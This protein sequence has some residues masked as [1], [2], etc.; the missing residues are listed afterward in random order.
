MARCSEQPGRFGTARVAKLSKEPGPDFTDAMLVHLLSTHER[1]KI[2]MF[3]H[4]FSGIWGMSSR[5]VQYVSGKG[6]R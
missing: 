5:V 6:R 2:W 4:E 3:D 1:A